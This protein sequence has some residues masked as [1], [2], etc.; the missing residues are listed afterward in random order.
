[1]AWGWISAP[2][3]IRVSAGEWALSDTSLAWQVAPGRPALLAEVLRW[4]DARAGGAPQTTT[5]RAGDAQALDE[6]GQAGYARDH[7]AP[8]FQ[9]N[10]R[11][12]DG[13]AEPGL[14]PGFRFLTAAQADPA[15]VVAAHRAAWHP[16]AFT[17]DSLNAVRSTWPYRDDLAVFV[18]A[19]DGR[20]V[21]S[22]LAWYDDVTRTAELEPVGTDPGFRRQG[23]GRAVSLFGL[24]QAREAGAAEAIVSCR[25]DERYPVPRRLY[26]SAGF[27]E[28]SRDLVFRK[29]SPR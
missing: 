14:P 29:T 28:L 27:T 15:L 2:E 11:A 1:V 3:R 25:G 22:A 18:Q 26:R 16:S 23:L 12:L 20:L 19:P 21:A 10:T 24:R 17:A 9:L 8:W 6:L 7:G 5:A 13:L 4:F